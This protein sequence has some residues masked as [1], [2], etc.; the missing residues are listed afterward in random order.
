M[1]PFDLHEAKGYWRIRGIEEDCPKW[2]GY[3][4]MPDGLLAIFDSYDTMSECVRFGITITHDHKNA[5][6][7]HD[8]HANFPTISTL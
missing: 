2:S 7:L 1:S 8:V 3:G 5:Y 6:G 4:T